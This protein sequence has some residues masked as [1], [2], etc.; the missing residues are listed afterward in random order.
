MTT[1]PHMMMESVDIAAIDPRSGLVSLRPAY[2]ITKAGKGLSYVIGRF[3]DQLQ[4]VD[5]RFTQADV[6][7]ALYRDGYFV[8]IHRFL[9]SHTLPTALYCGVNFADSSAAKATT[10]AN[11]H[12]DDGDA[13]HQQDDDD[14]YNAVPMVDLIRF[15]ASLATTH[16]TSARVI[17][18][19]KVPTS[20]L[21]PQQ[22]PTTAINVDTA[23]DPPVIVD[24][25]SEVLFGSVDREH[26]IDEFLALTNEV[27][28]PL[29]ETVHAAHMSNPD[30]APTGYTSS[31]RR[32]GTEKTF[33]DSMKAMSES[34]TV[35]T[36]LHEKT[37][38]T[39]RVV[40]LEEAGDVLKCITCSPTGYVRASKDHSVSTS[41]Q[42]LFAEWLYLLRG[43][44]A[45]EKCS[46]FYIA[47]EKRNTNHQQKSSAAASGNNTIANSTI[48]GGSA[49][50][51]STSV[52][53]DSTMI[54]S[55]SGSGPKSE[56]GGEDGNGFRI[57]FQMVP[58]GF[59]PRQEEEAWLA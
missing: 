43:K 2:T 50:L 29:T 14:D 8:R 9:T 27:L 11:N 41:V 33:R 25:S 36:R 19:L 24:L 56:D 12:H 22:Q 17:F 53:R 54:A 44:D 40:N 16:M 26:P 48:G 58:E 4:S 35:I 31:Y 15:T 46:G 10:A 30:I 7:S 38:V 37:G 55:G 23:M 57:D 13:A 47:S 20:G 39:K 1:T 52:R 34:I 59:G 51:P 3:L 49:V 42:E 5:A 18:A 21:L 28:M 6:M 45:K 32:A